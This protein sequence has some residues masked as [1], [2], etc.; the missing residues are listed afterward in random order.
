MPTFLTYPGS[1]PELRRKFGLGGAAVIGDLIYLGG[2]ALDLTTL[3]REAEAVTIADELRISFS[4]IRKTLE[5]AGCTLADVVKVNCYLSDDQYRAEFREAFRET[6]APGPYPKCLA[7][8]AGLAG[9]CR[10]EIE[11]VAVK[12]SGARSTVNPAFFDSDQLGRSMG[13]VAGGLV[14]AEAAALDWKTG[15]RVP[16]AATVADE[17]RICLDRLAAALEEAGGGFADLVKF[18]CYL[19]SDDD[20]AEFWAAFDERLA[21]GP[22]PPRL[23]QVTR[24]DGEA[25]VVIDAVAMAPEAP[26]TAT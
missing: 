3:T 6:F 24:V 8:V 26:N 11:V 19:T 17:T 7:I 2:M 1:D 5:L 16:E 23:T 22:C 14:F 25:R 20:R 12:P 13:V 21:P 9:D 4:G 10:V 18:N 15:Q